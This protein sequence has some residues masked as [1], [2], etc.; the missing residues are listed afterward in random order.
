L[1]PIDGTDSA[2]HN[3]IAAHHFTADV[4]DQDCGLLAMH[5]LAAAVQHQ[6]ALQ[7]T[8]AADESQQWQQERTSD[9]SCVVGYN[10]C[11]KSM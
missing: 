8:P 11:F 3:H 2:S 4:I 9:N 6:L 10:N 7:L 5:T 1:L